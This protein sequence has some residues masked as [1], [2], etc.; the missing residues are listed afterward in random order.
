MHIRYSIELK[1]LCQIRNLQ[2]EELRIRERKKQ[3]SRA[4]ECAQLLRIDTGYEP[5]LLD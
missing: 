4:S 5:L 3:R 1:K 2:R